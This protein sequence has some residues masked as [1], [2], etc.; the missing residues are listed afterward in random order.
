MSTAK[1]Q[2]GE[3][4]ASRYLKRRG[5][6]VIDRNVRAGRGELDI[7]ARKDDLLFFWK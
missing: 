2:V 3:E 4:R 7:V 6:K 5:Y 1:G